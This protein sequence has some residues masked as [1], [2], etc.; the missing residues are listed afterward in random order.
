ML[1]FLRKIR[2][3]LLAENKFSKYLL[4]A[5]GE[6]ILVVIGIL[7]ALQINNW[8]ESRKESA[9]EI[10]ILKAMKTDF[11]ETKIRVAETIELQR[12][13]VDNCYK[14]QMIMNGQRGV[15]S[16]GEFIYRGALSYWRI[17]PV[18][19]TYDG[20]IGSGKTDIL[21]NHFLESLLAEYSAE[22]K[23]GFEDEEFGLELNSI[24]TEKCSPYS[25]FLEPE[26]DRKEVGLE[27]PVSSENR[28]YAIREHLQ[29]NSFLGV[30]VAKSDMANNRLLYQKN[31]LDN[32]EDIISQIERELKNKN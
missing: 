25:A 6:I 26:R 2:K 31:I 14:L 22:I 28:N 9:E 18:N 10:A 23:Y 19:G 8:N 32:V 27:E 17:E 30:L 1:T 29:N 20:L 13:V 4:Y 12:Q 5:L 24:L 3:K 15:D 7:I 16:I 21:K 11:L